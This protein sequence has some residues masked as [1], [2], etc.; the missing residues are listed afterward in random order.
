MRDLYEGP[1][2]RYKTIIGLSD[3]FKSLHK[4]ALKGC[5]GGQRIASCS[6]DCQVV[7]INLSRLL[8]GVFVTGYMTARSHVCRGRGDEII[9]FEQ[10]TSSVILH[11]NI[12][13]AW[14]Y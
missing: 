3:Y 14:N 11:R 10:I 2:I 9:S 7:N 8:R 13:S 5:I 6:S 1:A 4:H 12:G